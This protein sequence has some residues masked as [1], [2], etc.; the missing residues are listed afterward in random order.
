MGFCTVFRA[1]YIFF[2]K[3]THTY[4]YITYAHKARDDASKEVNRTWVDI[5]SRLD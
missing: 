4:T 2:Y 3:D 1:R 5:Y